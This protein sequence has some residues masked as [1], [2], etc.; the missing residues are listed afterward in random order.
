MT[1]RFR[2]ALCAAL[3][4]TACD[5]A[6]EPVSSELDVLFTNDDGVAQRV[7]HYDPESGELTFV[8]RARQDM[9]E[10]L[11]AAGYRALV[12]DAGE[13]IEVDLDA[14]VVL[15][16]AEL[17]EGETFTLEIAGSQRRRAIL[18][19]LVLQAVPSGPTPRSGAWKLGNKVWADDWLAPV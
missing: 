5:S 10:R 14:G 2:M 11:D 6:H 19:E 9:R 8:P 18:G 16:T 17:E 15:V 3:V 12:D 13:R 1:T 4:I 7:G